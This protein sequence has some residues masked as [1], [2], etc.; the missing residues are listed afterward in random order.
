M[1]KLNTKIKHLLVAFFCLLAS[2]SIYSQV[3]LA[4]TDVMLQAFYWNSQSTTTWALL[5]NSAAEIAESFDLV[6]LPPCHNG[7]GGGTSNMGY[8]PIIWSGFN[9]S[10]GQKSTLQTLISTLHTGGAKVIADIV[11]NHR[12]GTTATTF[13]TDNFGTYGSTAFTKAQICS[14]DENPGTGAK[15]AGYETVCSAS[16]GYCSARDLDHSSSSVQAGINAYLQ[17]MKNEI[18]FDGWRFDLVKGYL[19]K[20][21]K[22]Y[23]QA[24]GNYFSVGEYYD[25]SYD[26]L[27]A[28]VNATSQSSMVFDFAF[29]KAITDWAKTGGT[30]YSGLSWLDGSTPRP[31]GLIHS[32]AMRQYAVTFI[33]NHDTDVSH[34][35]GTWPY[36][37]DVEKANAIMLSAAG[38]PCVFWK[39]WVSNKAAIKSM[40]AARKSVG[41]NSNSDVTITNKSGYYESTGIGTCGT[42][43]CRVGSWSGTPSGY[44]AACSGTGWAYYTKITGTNCG[45]SS[46]PGTD[47]G[48]VTIRFKAPASWTAAS[49]WAW[50]AS[51]TSE[52]FTGGTWPGTAMTLGT[53][54]Y[55]S[56]TLTNVTASTIGA[57]INNGVASGGEQTVDLT[58]TGNICWTAGS[59]T[60]GKYAVTVDATCSSAINEVEAKHLSIYPNPTQN[61]LSIDTE[62]QV[63]QVVIESLSGSVVKTSSD[64]K[65]NVSD[66]PA[67]MFLVKV[68]YVDN[69][70][71]TSKFIKY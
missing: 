35:G 15:D 1:K 54:G 70:V 60:S 61:V 16:G 26:A 37:G 18:G 8:H 24:A 5:N 9:S 53:D 13:Y 51:N 63:S 19:G 3:P 14:D 33:D 48:T 22:I 27:K 40:I 30:N 71:Q 59:L 69:T 28:W 32:S 36:T 39:H 64:L 68:V 21:T 6:W 10:W 66:L 17:Y 31:A 45:G 49:I 12:A 52:N 55:Y 4:S 62:D 29:K 25:P 34:T 46:D 2:T 47:I 44:T 58:T 23:T 41:L 11:L 67:G 65:V 50:D 38:I 20:Y 43:I 42:L 7:E 56:I 57:V